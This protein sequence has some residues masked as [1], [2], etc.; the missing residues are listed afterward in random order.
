MTQGNRGT[1]SHESRHV[2]SDQ[3]LDRMVDAYFDR[4]LSIGERR[5]LF[6]HLSGKNGRCEDIARMQRIL[7]QLRQPPEEIDVAD[8]VIA[9]VHRCRSFLSPSMRSAIRVGRVAVAAS[10]LLTFLGVV[11]VQRIAPDATNLVAETTPVTSLMEDTGSELSRIR[12]NLAGVS[13]QA[14]HVLLPQ[15]SRFSDEAEGPLEITVGIGAIVARAPQ[16]SPYL[17]ALERPQVVV[18]SGAGDAAVV[19]GWNIDDGSGTVPQG[20]ALESVM[21]RSQGFRTVE[22]RVITLDLSARI[23]GKR[24]SAAPYYVEHFEA[25]AL[26]VSFGPEVLQGVLGLISRT[27]EAPNTLLSPDR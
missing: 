15:W 18:L 25:S 17:P 26:P 22:S 24:A 6:D 16:A 11:I 23:D 2:L 27:S 8:E 13:E 4:D 9:Q 5:R 20:F 3:E 7:A 14:A 12:S 1:T 19:R 21:V 10:V